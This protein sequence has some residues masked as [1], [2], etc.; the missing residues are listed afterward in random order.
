[1]KAIADGVVQCSRCCSVAMTRDIVFAWRTI[2]RMP[3]LAVVVI[4]S[5]GVGIGVNTVVFSW[6]QS[7]LFRPIAGVRHAGDF[8]LVEP[9]TDSGIYPAAS[10]LEYRDLAERL[11]TMEALIAFRMV[12]LY[13]GESG[14]VERG[15]GL[16]V[17]GN[18]FTALGLQPALG[19]FLL[20]AEAA[21]PGSA[22]LVVISHDYWQARFAGAPAVVGKS[23]RLNGIDVTVI[24]VAP[25]GFQGTIM[26]LSFDLFLPATIAP[27]IFSGSQE[28][29]DRS[30]RGYSMMGRLA[31]GA[32]RTLA[33]TEL[34]TVM[35]DLARAYPKSNAAVA[36]EVRSFWE[37]PRGP[38]RLLAASLA[39]LQ[40]IMLLLLLAVCGNAANLVMARAS[41]RQREMSVRLALGAGRWRVVRLL[42]TESVLL[43]LIGATLGAAIA[44]WGTNA[45]TA[46][47]PMR[48]RGIPITFS[49][50]VDSMGLAFAMSLGIACGI[51]FGLGPALQ[52]ARLDPQ[53]ILRGGVSTP[54]RSR[55]RNTLMA[56][57]VALAIVVL[58]AAGLFFRS[59][60]ET[61]ETDPGFRRD[62]VLLAAYDLT[63][64]RVD[65]SGARWF[66][67]RLLDRLHAVPGAEAVAIAGAVPLDIHGM[68]TRFFTLD[69]RARDDGMPDEALANTV[70][71]GYFAVM[72]IPLLA[73]TDFASLADTAT[74]PQVI[75]NE[76]FVR[77]YLERADP[78]GRRL[79]LGGRAYSI[80]GVARN[81]LY[82]AFGEPPTPIIYLSYRDRPSPLGEIHMRTRAGAE[83]AVASDVRRIVRDLDADL[84]IF[85]VRTLNDHIES[86]LILRRIPARMFAVL[87]PLLL[88]MAA[89]G[90]YAVV[91]YTVSLRTAEIGVR[92]ALGATGR[93]IVRE[94]VADSLRVI[95]VGA[96]AGWIVAFVLAVDILSGGPIDVAVFAA[97]P[98]ILLSVAAI[99][100]WLPARRATT[101]DP[102]VA[103]RE[104]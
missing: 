48:V 45:L 95:V 5:L 71:P 2:V 60:I 99:A 30:V 86:N 29:E 73:G 38:Q 17:S 32:T 103:L 4:L 41:A 42:L 90:I 20:P 67:T 43:S 82:N 84:P 63:E 93:R 53:Q 89:I 50:D 31:H 28:L 36:A 98:A 66:A 83:T 34:D 65:A 80:V 25:R 61:R 39:F 101:V 88:L 37:S 91:S 58:L 104:A 68:P 76:E 81:A 12:P 15:N 10:W 59:F 14:R 6:M 22:R 56:L 70:T 79:E 8:H 62:G 57:E 94:F 44:F 40:A 18:Y 69:G 26:R 52:L 27:V 16:L 13:V 49:T 33:Q 92:L 96:I 87:A 78:L 97:V 3:A 23:I 46:A 51:I 9:R 54:R 100:A 24:G 85:D 35:R 72:G 11:R 75:V 47:P 64:R 102:A 21:T 1:M 7:V 19:R 77:R 74:S 55:M